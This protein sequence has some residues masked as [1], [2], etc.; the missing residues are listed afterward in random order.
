MSFATFAQPGLLSPLQGLQGLFRWFSAGSTSTATSMAD[1]RA[2]SMLTSA[3]TVAAIISA[4]ENATVFAADYSTLTGTSQGIRSSIHSFEGSGNVVATCASQRAT[5]Q[6]VR[7]ALRPA[8]R[9]VHVS[10]LVE[11]GQASTNVGRMVISGRMEDV[12]AELDR[13]VLREATLH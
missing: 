11:V 5:G 2:D 8:A 12:C 3:T 7:S 10:R 1:S 6:V 13:L 9:R 4:T